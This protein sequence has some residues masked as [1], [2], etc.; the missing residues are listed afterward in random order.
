MSLRD[1]KIVLAFNFMQK[2]E[3]AN[4]SFTL[5]EF[6]TVTNWKIS[7]IKTY[8]KKQWK[9]FIYQNK[10][11]QT[12]FT[13]GL[14]TIDQDCFL[15]LHSQKLKYRPNIYHKD[16][17]LL[18]KSRQFSSLAI[19]VFNNPY[20]EF[21]VHGFIVN[22]VVAWT[23][24]LHAIF[25]KKNIDYFYRDI[26]GKA[27]L[28]DGDEK[29]WELRHCIDKY[30]PNESPIKS[31]LIFLIG[32]RNKIEHRDLPL[33]E[34]KVAGHCQ[35]CINNFEQILINEFG[36][37]HALNKNI[38]LALQLSRSH[39]Q[40]SA[41]NNIQLYVEPIYQYIDKFEDQ[42]PNDFLKSPEYRISYFLT[43][44]ISNHK[45]TSTVT[46]EILTSQADDVSNYDKVMIKEKEKNKLKPKQIVALMHKEGF[47]K[48]TI[49]HHTKLWQAKKAKKNS[50][51][52]V[53]LQDS[54]WYWYDAWIEV[55]R[56]YCKEYDL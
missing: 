32:L 55:V 4:G 29:A 18:I 40:M 50:S 21:K 37:E 42:L 39:E 3:I 46:I 54:S 23:A 48:F 45:T 53:Q 19:Y 30:W 11:E 15:K 44:K 49:N 25:E 20:S 14:T 43:P 26:E 10:E 13:R 16:D 6:S 41:L 24:L 47:K 8:I 52:G 38:T 5:I 33:I 36:H 27:K 28:I 17:S 9:D 56:A 1:N 35:S 34:L 7:T 12:Y 51:Y 2:K 22:I 31:N